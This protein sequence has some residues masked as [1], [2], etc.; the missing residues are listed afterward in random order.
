MVTRTELLLKYKEVI[1]D[2]I[3]S[4]NH[5]DVVVSLSERIIVVNK[6][7]FW[8]WAESKGYDSY[9]YD[10]NDPSKH[11]GHGQKSGKITMDDY[12]QNTS[13]KERKIDL[14]EFLT[15]TERIE[16]TNKF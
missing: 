9:C 2:Y 11:D 1:L 8:R 14:Y 15:D 12:F 13:M 3:D 5:I 6:D 7:A 4:S 10:Y 16:F